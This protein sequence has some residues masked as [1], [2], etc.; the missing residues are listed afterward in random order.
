MHRRLVKAKAGLVV[1]ALIFLSV[2]LSGCFYLVLGAAAA[3]G[4]YAISSD[5][6]QGET[7]KDFQEVWDSSVEIASIMGMVG[8]KSHELGKISAVVDGAKI[9]IQI[10]QL[11]SST[12]RLKVRARKGLFPNISTAQNIFVKIMNRING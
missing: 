12:T 11:T 7:E 3:A 1:A 6:I 8:S 4:G 10:L 2:S 9:N 5:T